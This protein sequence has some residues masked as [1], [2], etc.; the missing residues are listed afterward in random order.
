MPLGVLSLRVRDSP[1]TRS[2]K[3]GQR[4]FPNLRSGNAAQKRCFDY[5]FRRDIDVV[6]ASQ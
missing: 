4:R 1:E 3:P 2:P 6:W 5:E